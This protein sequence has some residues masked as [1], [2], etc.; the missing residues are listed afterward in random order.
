MPDNYLIVPTSDVT[1]GRID[2]LV[3]ARHATDQD[4]TVEGLTNGQEVTVYRLSDGVAGT[5][6]AVETGPVGI[7]VDNVPFPDFPVIA[8]ADLQSVTLD[9][10]GTY[11][12]TAPTDI[13]ARVLNAADD[14]QILAL[15]QIT[16]T[17]AADGAWAG[18]VSMTPGNAAYIAEVRHGASGTA[19]VQTVGFR[20]C[21]A[22]INYGQSN[23]LLFGT[24]VDDAVTARSDVFMM[25]RD[26]QNNNAE[27]YGAPTGGGTIALLNGLAAE[28]GISWVAIAGGTSGVKARILDNIITTGG[29]SDTDI[30]DRLRSDLAKLNR[31][32]HL[33]NWHQG[34]GDSVSV[35]TGEPLSFYKDSIDNIFDTILSDFG[36]SAPTDLPVI[37]SSLSTVAQSEYTG[38]AT[39]DQFHLDMVSSDARY[40]WGGSWK[41][42]QRRDNFHAY[43]SSYTRRGLRILDRAKVI[44]GLQSETG[45]FEIASAERIDATTTRVT[46]THGA[47]TDFS[48]VEVIENQETFGSNTTVVR[49]F[50]I[51]DDGVNYVVATG[52]RVNGNTIELTHASLATTGC[53]LHH[54]RGP[55]PDTSGMVVD[56]SPEAVPLLHTALT[57]VTV[58][59]LGAP[60][61]VSGPAING[62]EITFEAAP[63]ADEIVWAFSDTAPTYTDAGGWVN[64]DYVT[65]SQALSQASNTF[66]IDSGNTPSGSRALYAY[67]VDAAGQVSARESLAATIVAPPS[68]GLVVTLREAGLIQE[69][70]LADERLDPSTY[71]GVTLTGSDVADVEIF[72]AGVFSNSNRDFTITVAG[73]TPVLVESVV[74]SNRLEIFRYRLT[75]VP[76]N[77][78]GDIVITPGAATQMEARDTAVISIEGTYTTQSDTANG[79]G[80]STVYTLDVDTAA[81]GFAFGI[82]QSEN[83]SGSW[84]WTG[85]TE[86]SS[87][88]ASVFSNYF[89]TALVNPSTD[90]TPLLISATRTQGTA[91]GAMV[92]S[93]SEA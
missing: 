52:A 84:T 49:G 31:L 16:I 37:I 38:W 46:V 43:G 19:D 82:A 70:D 48:I 92:V 8:D 66:T 80:S 11:T 4:L 2:T 3:N 57:P 91:G 50:E 54:L 69:M 51:S 12:G 24:T 30:L 35:I 25:D 15:T 53:T 68:S 89:S 6:V 26:G 87:G 93:W 17:A 79:G 20:T 34:E 60:M 65:G 27:R 83:G 9:L 73:L 32:P 63:G 23:S 81:G 67:L 36:S 1:G 40:H 58:E 61:W 71:S 21:G 64:A 47:G 44:L 29:D 13:R 59:A 77:T 7:T 74:Q 5:P 33:A 88:G 18:I 45:R 14:S 55:V 75:G 42:A 85:L 62:T 39:V 28:T 72:V 76:A 41:D 22:V 86:Q 10:T 90:A 56:N 78:T